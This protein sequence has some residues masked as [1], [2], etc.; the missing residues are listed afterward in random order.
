MRI[1][2]TQEQLYQIAFAQVHTKM[3]I[4][5]FTAV[6]FAVFGT[7]FS[8]KLIRS[9]R[10]EEGDSVLFF[11]PSAACMSGA[12]IFGFRAYAMWCNPAYYV[13]VD[14]LKQLSQ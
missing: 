1:L 7:Y 3:I 9:M 5:L 2:F 10:T 8:Y 11:L 4:F 13:I 14:V 12:I 6:I